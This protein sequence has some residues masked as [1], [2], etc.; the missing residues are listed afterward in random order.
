M[1]KR[2]V[3]VGASSG[4]GN[5]LAKRY[6]T[7]G[8]RV[9]VVARREALLQSLAAEFPGNIVSCTADITADDIESRLDGLIG[10]LGGLDILIV[11]ASVVFLVDDVLDEKERQTVFINVN[12]FF[13]VVQYGWNYFKA[14]GGGQIA[15]VSSIAAAR[16]NKGAPSYHASKAF[17]AAYLEGLRVKALQEGKNIVITQLVPGY[18]DTAMGVGERVFWTTPVAKAAKLVQKAIAKRK[19][20][21]FIPKRWFWIFHLQ[22]F[23]PTF[24]YDWL[25][26]GSWKLRTKR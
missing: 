1:S 11:A 5:E 19:K 15:G 7:E 3:V 6:A 23:L 17:Q 24:I 10:E 4:L 22:R 18:L 2:I 13:R 25:V 20:V 9:G 8:H 16:G 12:G 26:N 14:N 21:A